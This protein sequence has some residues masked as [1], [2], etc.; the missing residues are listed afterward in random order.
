MN[1]PFTYKISNFQLAYI[2]YLFGIVE[3]VFHCTPHFNKTD[4]SRTRVRR[5]WRCEI[6]SH[7]TSHPSSKNIGAE[8]WSSW[9]GAI[10]AF[11]SQ[12]RVPR[13]IPITISRTRVVQAKVRH[14]DE[15]Q[16]TRTADRE[17]NCHRSKGVNRM[18]NLK[19]LTWCKMIRGRPEQRMGVPNQH[20]KIRLANAL[21]YYEHG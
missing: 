5:G 21:L 14:Q 11:G 16:S 7:L 15:C 13:W 2:I 18:A 19:R 8:P 17:Q 9:A 3:V 1:W 20:N 12:T 4:L 6:V 10:Y